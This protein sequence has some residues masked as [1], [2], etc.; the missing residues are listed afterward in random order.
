MVFPSLFVLP[1]SKITRF[2]TA[3]RYGKETP[4]PLNQSLDKITFFKIG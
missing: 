1:E 2:Q 4:P 3:V